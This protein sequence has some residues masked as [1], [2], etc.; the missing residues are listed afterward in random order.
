[1]TDLRT[2]DHRLLT[3][4]EIESLCA[5]DDE[6]EDE[7]W[8]GSIMP[9]REAVEDLQVRFSKLKEM[10][11]EIVGLKEQVRELRERVFGEYAASPEEE[12]GEA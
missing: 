12:D 5:M 2:K 10:D 8:N 3:P 4:E 7:E 9:L 6:Q 1:M 11:A